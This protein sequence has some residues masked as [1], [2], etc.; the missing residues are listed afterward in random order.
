MQAQAGRFEEERIEEY[1]RCQEASRQSQAMRCSGKERGAVLPAR[2][3]DALPGIC[4]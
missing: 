1:F 2:H 3:M 4:A